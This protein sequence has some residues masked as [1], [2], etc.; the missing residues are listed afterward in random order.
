MVREEVTHWLKQANKDF[1]V[2]KKNF[3]IEEY[4]SAAFWSQQAVEKGLKAL[5]LHKKKEKALGHSLVYL[6]RDAGIPSNIVPKLKKLS[7]QYFLAR[8]PDASE[9]VPY[10]LYDKVTS[11]EF[12]DI[13][14]EVLAWINKHF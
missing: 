2:A 1:E 14:Q 4:Y 9:E 7:P 8:Y 10:D 3:E 13:A 5:I 11:K 12:L 6:G